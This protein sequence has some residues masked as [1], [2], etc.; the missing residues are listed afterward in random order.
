[1]KYSIVIPV[2]RAEGCLAELHR[3]ITA[4]MENVGVAY[5]LILVE[6]C[7][8]DNS[9]AK[10][11]E[12]AKLD[13]R[14]VG[15]KLSRNFGQHHA[16]TAGLD[17]ANGDR[18]IIMD[19]DLQDSPED[20]PALCA[21]ADEGFDVVVAR[22]ETRNDAAW[23]KLASSCFYRV[24]S[25][26]SGYEFRYGTRPFRVMTR[27]ACDALKQMREQMRTLEPLTTWIGFKVAFVTLEY[28]PRAS[29]QSSYNPLRLLKLAFTTVVCFSDKPLRF[30][31]W[32][33]FAVALLAFLYGVFSWVRSVA[34]GAEISDFSALAASIYFI[35]GVLLAFMGVQGVYI[36]RIFDETK[37]RPLYIVAKMTKQGDQSV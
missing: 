25:W 5:E 26:M 23:K 34:T 11:V 16:I 33:G 15:L 4:T 19:C 13:S 35:G 31:I 2:Y 3:R 24:F 22:W 10:I 6:D 17:A 1:M 30:S 27:T 18:V 9:W 36:A 32:L 20:I 37:R 7:G 21:K 12:I 8:G 14:V 29:G 28:R